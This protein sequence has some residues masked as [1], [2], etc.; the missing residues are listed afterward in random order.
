[1]INRKE[2]EK[3][4]N[5]YA[6]DNWEDYGEFNYGTMSVEFETVPYTEVTVKDES[7]KVVDSWTFKDNS[8]YIEEDLY[9]GNFDNYDDNY[10]EPINTELIDKIK[11]ILTPE[12]FNML[13]DYFYCDDVEDLILNIAGSASD[14]LSD[15]A[16]P[17][18]EDISEINN[19]INFDFSFYIKMQNIIKKLLKLL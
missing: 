2:I 11:P 15:G 6:N 14:E 8:T 1:M 18:I 10:D 19:F 5:D 4:I 3:Q 13:E 9:E 12:E 17:Y 16:V 7:G